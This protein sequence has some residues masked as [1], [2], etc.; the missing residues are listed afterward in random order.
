MGAV[1]LVAF[2]SFYPQIPGLIGENGILPAS[3]YLHAVHEQ[4]GSRGY[5][6]LPTL[7]WLRPTQG[8]IQLLAGAGGGFSFLAVICVAAGAGVLALLVLFLFLVLGGQD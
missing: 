1:Y 8:F 3:R 6:L 2:A 7:A 4:L 5:Y